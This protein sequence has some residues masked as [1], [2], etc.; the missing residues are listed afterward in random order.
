MSSKC[1]CGGI[2]FAFEI[3]GGVDAALRAHRVRTL[4]GDDG[5][6]VNIAAGFGDLDDGRESGEA[7]ANHDDS[8]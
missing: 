2:A 5:E 6:Q 3:L 7:S 8:G 4:D 1:L